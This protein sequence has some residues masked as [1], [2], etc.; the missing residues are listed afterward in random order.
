MLA[1]K[2]CGFLREGQSIIYICHIIR[3]LTEVQQI[4][5][6]HLKNL[7][8]APIQRQEKIILL[9]I[10]GN[11]SSA[12]TLLSRKPVMRVLVSKMPERPAALQHGGAKR[13]RLADN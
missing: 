13:Q 11:E 8:F 4:L 12:L 9:L 1:R 7:Y 3:I 2:T 6:L 10:W 5:S